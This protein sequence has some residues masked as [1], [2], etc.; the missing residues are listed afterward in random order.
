MVHRDIKP[1]NVIL[2]QTGVAKIVDFGLARLASSGTS[3][4]SMSTAKPS[5]TCRPNRR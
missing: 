2:T 4:Q 1:S 3:T 5:A